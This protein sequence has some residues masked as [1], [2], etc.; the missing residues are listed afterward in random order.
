MDTHGFYYVLRNSVL[1]TTGLVLLLRMLAGLLI[2]EGQKKAWEARRYGQWK[3][4]P[5]N[6]AVDLQ[7]AVS[8]SRSARD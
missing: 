5:R 8:P 7:A 6:D 1:P 4:Q 3:W 2:F